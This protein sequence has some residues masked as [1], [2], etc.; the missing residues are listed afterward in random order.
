MLTYIF[1]ADAFFS[2]FANAT[3]LHINKYKIK[4]ANLQK[5]P[6]RNIHNKLNIFKFLSK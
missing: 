6:L 3:N 4:S 1:S 2:L 5:L